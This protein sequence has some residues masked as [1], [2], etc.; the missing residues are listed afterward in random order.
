MKLSRIVNVSKTLLFASMLFFISIQVAQ[1]QP[2]GRMGAGGDPEQVAD[3]QTTQMTEWLELT[4]KQIPLVREIN[5]KHAKKAQETRQV[6]QGDPDKMREAMKA[7]RTERNE[8]LKGVLTEA[9]Y[10]KLNERQPREGQQVDKGKVKD[11]DKAKGKGSK[12]KKNYKK[13]RSGE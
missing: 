4:E 5:L 13:P 2:G 7:L 9:Q 11:K 6:N 1:A 8:Q 12:S 10:Q 3:R